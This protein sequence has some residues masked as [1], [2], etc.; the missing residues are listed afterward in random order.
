MKVPSC[1]S[2][3]IC[4]CGQAVK[5]ED[6]KEIG[7]CFEEKFFVMRFLCSDCGFDGRI[8]YKKMQK[9]IPDLCRA[10]LDEEAEEEDS[11]AEKMFNLYKEN[12][13]CLHIPD[14]NDESYGNLMS[15]FEVPD[16]G[17]NS[18]Q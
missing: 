2:S 5:E 13:G 17:K 10:I 9:S 15:H 4:K 16:K 3:R 12:V 14:W 11:F 18:F 7:I 1:F 6:I 8:K